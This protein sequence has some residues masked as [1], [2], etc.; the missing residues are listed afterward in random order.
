[1]IDVYLTI[2]LIG[3]MIGSIVC[4]RLLRLL[5][6][7]WCCIRIVKLFVTLFYIKLGLYFSVKSLNSGGPYK[8]AQ[9]RSDGDMER[10]LLGVSLLAFHIRDE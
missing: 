2:E 4:E 1:M 9:R 6:L 7:F 8:E 3:F 10:A 5:I